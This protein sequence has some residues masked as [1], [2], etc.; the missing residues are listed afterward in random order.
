MGYAWLI[1]IFAF[2]GAAGSVAWRKF[3]QFARVTPAIGFVLAIILYPYWGHMLNFDGRS[4]TMYERLLTQSRVLWFH[5][6]Q[7][8]LPN[9]GSFS[10]YHDDFIISK[11]FF[12]PWVT[13][14]AVVGHILLICSAFV[15]RKRYPLFSFG[16][17][18]FYVGHSL[19]SSVF[20]LEIMYEHRNYLPMIGPMIAVMGFLVY[21]PPI[22]TEGG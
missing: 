13:F 12:D 6:G 4:F 14:L 19:E 22:N 10:L 8:F 11:G 5:L 9:A 16:I 21:R 7:I 2:R 1:E 15:L 18:W 3:L 20:P 17:A